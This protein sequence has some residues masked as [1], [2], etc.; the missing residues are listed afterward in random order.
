MGNYKT[1]KLGHYQ[2][3]VIV[4]THRPKASVG[5]E[6]QAVITACRNGRDSAVNDLFRPIGVAVQSAI[7]KLTENI[8]THRPKA[9]VGFEKQAVIS[10]RRNG[11]DTAGHDF[12]GPISADTWAVTQ[13]TQIIVTHHP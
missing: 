4:D 9:A 3:A 13:L 8:V 6:K 7:A 11:S 12:F 10:S 1:G 2:F 5:F